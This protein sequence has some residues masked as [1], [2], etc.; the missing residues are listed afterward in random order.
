MY[1]IISSRVCYYVYPVNNALLTRTKFHSV[2]HVDG[3][4]SGEFKCDNGKCVT[5][6]YQCDNKDDCGDNS[7]EQGCGELMEYFLSKN[8]C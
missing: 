1:H 7:D 4:S 2:L 6:S 8:V 3:C 5:S